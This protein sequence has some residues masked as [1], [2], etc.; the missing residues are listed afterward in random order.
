VVLNYSI[1]V[2]FFISLIFIFIFVKSLCK[3]N[4]PLKSPFYF[5]LTAATVAD[6]LSEFYTFKVYVLDQ[7]IWRS[8][9]E[10]IRSIYTVTYVSSIATDM[11]TILEAVLNMNRL[12]AL[13]FPFIHNRV[14]SFYHSLG[15]FSISLISSLLLEYLAGMSPDRI[16]IVYGFLGIVSLLSAVIMS[17]TFKLAKKQTAATPEIVRAERMLLY[18]T[19]FVTV[20]MT[21]ANVIEWAVV[22]IAKYVD[23]HWLVVDGLYDLHDL[24]ILLS[25]P[26]SLLLLYYVS[27]AVRAEFRDTFRF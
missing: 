24:C 17:I 7:A 20:L 4:S 6:I 12:T 13:V 3:K 16:Y 11:D 18:N 2:G 9:D 23:V 15:I 26:G 22:Y 5:F 14:W 21:I 10:T 8:Q 19:T 27:N 1:L 25:N